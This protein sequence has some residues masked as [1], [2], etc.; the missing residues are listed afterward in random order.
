M[1]ISNT[2]VSKFLKEKALELGLPIM[3]RKWDII[4]LSY[5]SRHERARKMI[6]LTKMLMEEGRTDKEIRKI[7][8]I[9]PAAFYN[10]VRRN[11]LRSVKDE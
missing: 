11:H 3:R 6:A 4:D 5:E 2:T 10:M 7:L 8:G 1:D 9:K